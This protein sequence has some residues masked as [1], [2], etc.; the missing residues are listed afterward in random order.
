MFHFY[1]YGSLFHWY[2]GILFE[3]IWNI[4]IDILLE[5]VFNIDRKIR[6]LVFYSLIL[7]GKICVLLLHKR[8]IFIVSSVVVGLRGF[9]F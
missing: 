6:Y 8:Q 1:K 9:S 5:I 4:Q 7:L 3:V 2:L